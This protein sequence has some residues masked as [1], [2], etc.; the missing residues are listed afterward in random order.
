VGMVS[1]KQSWKLAAWMLVLANL[2]L[3][4]VLVR[5]A[6]A[7]QLEEDGRCDQFECGCTGIGTG[8][9]QCSLGIGS[10]TCKGLA[11]CI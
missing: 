9:V 6:S 4:G 7:Q 1:W 8:G 3:A 10:K 2:S 11:D 5:R